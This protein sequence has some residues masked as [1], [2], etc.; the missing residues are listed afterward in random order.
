MFETTPPQ[1]A[2]DLTGLAAD[3]TDLADPVAAVTAVELSVAFIQL[4]MCSTEPVIAELAG[5]E[6]ML[7]KPGGTDLA[8]RVFAQ[9]LYRKIDALVFRLIR[10]TVP[11]A[12]AGFALSGI[13]NALRGH[14]ADIVET[15]ATHLLSH[16]RDVAIQMA[17]VATT[18][19]AR[20]L[21]AQVAEII[22]Q[23]HQVDEGAQ[24]A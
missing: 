12:D 23:T 21:R 24:P 15:A 17:T 1:P 13:E 16:D 18:M 5:Q 19:A 3:L 20:E 4:C 2:P 14:F 10:R 9:R 7:R 11:L 8:K 22:G 6:S